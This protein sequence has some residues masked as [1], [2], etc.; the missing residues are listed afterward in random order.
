M[1]NVKANKA[2]L[3]SSH[4]H[5]HQPQPITHTGYK[6]DS[7]SRLAA[8]FLGCSTIYGSWLLRA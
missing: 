6:E 7:Q 3:G 5:A 8:S 4:T 2:S 1:S